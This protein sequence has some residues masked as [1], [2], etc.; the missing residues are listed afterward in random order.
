MKLAIYAGAGFQAKDSALFW[1]ALVGNVEIVKMLLGKGANPNA[2]QNLTQSNQNYR[3]SYRNVTTP[4]ANGIDSGNKEIVK[5]LINAGAD[6][7]ARFGNDQN[8]PLIHAAF[9]GNKEIVQILIAAGADVNAKDYFGYTALS[10]VKKR[11]GN[12]DIIQILEQAGARRS[13]LLFKLDSK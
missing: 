12:K 7:N 9:R 3:A 13:F 1:A 8:T 4:L 2:L 5:L 11:G 10:W 6:L